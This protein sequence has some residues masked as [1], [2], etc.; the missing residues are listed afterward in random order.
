MSVLITTEILG[1]HPVLTSVNTKLDLVNAWVR[2]GDGLVGFGE[3]KKFEVKGENRFK[4]AKTWWEDRVSEL[5]IQNNV[6]GSGTGPILFSSF[7]FDPNEISVLVIPE[8]LIGQKNGKSWITWIGDVKQ[9]NLEK[10]N[11]APVSGEIKWQEGSISEQAWQSQVSSAINA[12]KSNKLEKVVLA[13]DI[14]ATSKT[15]IGVRSLLQRLEIEYPST[16]IFLVDGLIGA[17]PELLVRLSKSLVTSR[18]LAGTIR[19]TGNEDRDLTLAAS[20]AKSSKDLEEHEYAVRSVADALAP[21]CSSTNVPEAPF[22]LH[23]SNV[24]HLATDVTGVLNDSA[25]QSDIFTL[26]EQLHPS[27]AVCGTPAL[28]AKKLI[29]E[30]EQMNRQRYAGPVGWI[31]AN[32]DGE[33]AIALR[34]GQL[35]N[36]RNSIRIFAGCGIVAGSD[37][38]TEFAESQAKLMPM[39]TALETL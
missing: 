11:T 34:C 29:V 12:I 21:F 7:S 25:K 32:N 16:W 15:E 35:S 8:I 13:R 2:S 23:L 37:P 20:L 10:I 9:P 4:E 6:H 3:Y 17:T 1:E 30:L 22:V 14:T 33:I 39:R 19:K 26:I 38:A 24:M 31:D 28:E 18:V 5:K 27:A 36:D